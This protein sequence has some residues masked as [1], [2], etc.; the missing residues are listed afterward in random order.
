[1][2]DPFS[3]ERVKA[4]SSSGG[5]DDDFNENSTNSFVP[6]TIFFPFTVPKAPNPGSCLKEFSA[7]LYVLMP[8]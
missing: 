1:M 5:K 3:F 4:S 2:V 8:F 6:I 7:H